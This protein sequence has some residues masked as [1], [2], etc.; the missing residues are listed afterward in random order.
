[1]KV[2]AFAGSPRRNGNTRI[3]LDAFIDE[4]TKRGHEVEL[5]D[6][7][8]T[9]RWNINPCLGCD[10]CLSGRCI[11]TIQCRRSTPDP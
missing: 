6:L 11:G 8:N 7:T 5:I 10:S 1:M 2:L 9:A 3:L 4:C